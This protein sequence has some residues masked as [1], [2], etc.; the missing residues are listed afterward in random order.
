MSTILFNISPKDTRKIHNIQELN[1]SESLEV[2]CDGCSILTHVVSDFFSLV[3]VTKEEAGGKSE[4][5][6]L[7]VTP[8]FYDEE[9]NF[10]NFT[11]NRMPQPPE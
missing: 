4:E 1:M 3:L 10:Q 8:I 6:I 11:M 7:H 9:E 5:R 2:S